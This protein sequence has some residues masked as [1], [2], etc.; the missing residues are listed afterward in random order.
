L[1]ALQ[2]KLKDEKEVL[3]Q[4]ITLFHQLEKEEG[5]KLIY[6]VFVSK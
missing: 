1:V 3:E 6:S 4:K 2:N 5:P